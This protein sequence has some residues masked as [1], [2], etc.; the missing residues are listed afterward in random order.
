MRS[1]LTCEAWWGLGAGGRVQVQERVSGV[2][3]S[4]ALDGGQEPPQ[5]REAEAH[6]GGTGATLSWKDFIY[7]CPLLKSEGLQVTGQILLENQFSSKRQS[8]K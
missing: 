4:L 3:L 7:R 5:F 2:H 1:A 8:L 6:C